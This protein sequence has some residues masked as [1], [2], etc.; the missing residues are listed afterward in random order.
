MRGPTIVWLLFISLLVHD[1][2]EI[3]FFGQLDIQQDSG[4]LRISDQLPVVLWITQS[5]AT[6][7]KENNLAIALMGVLVLG[8]AAMGY[9]NPGKWGLVIFGVFLGGYFL[10]SFTHLGQSIILKKYTPGVITA[11]TV[12]FPASVFIYVKLFNFKLLNLREALITAFIG[13]A[14]FVPLIVIVNRVSKAFVKLVQTQ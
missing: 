10:H 3:L 4:I 2:E 6:N 5:R 8:V 11:I 9:F 1:L 14:I 12:V 13:L 7:P